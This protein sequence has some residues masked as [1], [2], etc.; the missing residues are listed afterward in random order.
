MLN[1]FGNM[2]NLASAEIPELTIMANAVSV[3]VSVSSQFSSAPNSTTQQTYGEIQS[4]IATIQQGAQSSTL[5][6][7]HH[8]LS[9]YHLLGTVGQLVGSLVWTLDEAGYL[10]A[11]RQA[12]TF[13]VYQ[14]LLPTVWAM[15]E[16]INCVSDN[17]PNNEIV[18]NAPPAGPYIYPQ[19]SGGNFSALLPDQ[20]DEGS[21]PGCIDTC[22]QGLCIETC[23]FGPP[24]PA[25]TNV[26]F[27]LIS[28]QCTYTP[29]VSTHG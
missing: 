12:F 24:A 29:G 8:I 27:T 13:W 23:G 20:D 21:V 11:S 22:N 17:D 1:L 9:D 19:S 10:S 7:K 5:A 28:Q 18:W 15:W 3:A 4:E 14:G 16:V 6:Q 26:V 2:L 25:T